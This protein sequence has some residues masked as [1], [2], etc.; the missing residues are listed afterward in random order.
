MKTSSPLSEVIRA[1]V[2]NDRKNIPYWKEWNLYSRYSLFEA[3]AESLLESA[4]SYLDDIDCIVSLSKS[5]FPLGSWFALKTEKPLFLFS[6]G[7]L[8]HP[9]GVSVIGLYPEGDIPFKRA[10]VVDS[11]VNTGMTYRLFTKVCA[12][13]FDKRVFA[14]LVDVRNADSF[15]IEDSV[16]QLYNRERVWPAL[17]EIDG[18]DEPLLGSTDF[19]MRDEEYWLSGV[20]R[21]S[22]ETEGKSA[23]SFEHIRNDELKK[24]LQDCLFVK[25][26]NKWNTVSPLKL[27]QDPALF[28]AVLDEVEKRLDIQVDTVVASSLGAVPLAIGLCLKMK[29]K[30]KEKG[31]RRF[32]FFGNGSK[33]FYDSLFEGSRNIL[34]CDDMVASGGLLYRIYKEFIRN[35]RKLVGV[36]TIF[37]QREFLGNKYLTG[38][39]EDAKYLAFLDELG[40]RFEN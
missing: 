19:W 34:L 28:R 32:I 12:N 18:V 16:V 27:Y 9:N 21:I 33:R 29:Q 7:E 40:D 1:F 15:K 2:V 11:H 20:S 5:G 3:Q 25:Y 22:L 23:I 8:F 30:Q 24:R 39:P 14:V 35:T 10:L 26:L 4:S 37:E 17:L 36:V 38:L 13:L 6:I 31:D